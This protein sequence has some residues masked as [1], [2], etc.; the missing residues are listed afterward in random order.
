VEQLDAIARQFR[1][2]QFEQAALSTRQLLEGALARSPDDLSTTAEALIFRPELQPLFAAPGRVAGAVPYYRW[3][4]AALERALGPHH[5]TVAFAQTR[6][7]STLA[8]AGDDESSGAV[9]GEVI[10]RA[11]AA[12]AEEIA[13]EQ[14]ARLAAAAAEKPRR[15]TLE[16]AVPPPP[17]IRTR[18]MA[19]PPVP[20][21]QPQPTPTPQPSKRAR[22]ATPPPPPATTRRRVC[23][24]LTG[25]L[26]QA[27]EHGATVA[28]RVTPRSRSARLWIYLDGVVLDAGGLIERLA[29]PAC[30]EAYSELDTGP[31]PAYGLVCTEHRDAVLGL[32]PTRAAGAALVR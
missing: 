20:P 11:R 26:A 10:V 9:L 6:L 5:L 7:A 31:R 14:R 1:D 30:V 29:L 2:G 8:L 24:H 28:A 32:H 27:R 16:I 3:L 12:A 22:R 15:T 23:E 21:P 13:A 17:A 25:V 19:I 18:E 4:T